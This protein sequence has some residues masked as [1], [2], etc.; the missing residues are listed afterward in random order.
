MRAWAISPAT[1][2]SANS[3]AAFSLGAV[4]SN[5]PIAVTDVREGVDVTSPRFVLDPVDETFFDT[6]PLRWRFPIDL[7]ADPDQVWAGLTARRPLWWCR[8]LTDVRFVNDPPYG[9]G[10]AR[11]VELGRTLRMEEHFFRWEEHRR[12]HSF[13]VTRANLP[14]FASFAEDYRVDATARGSRFVWT[15]AMAPRRGFTASSAIGRPMTWALLASLVRDTSRYF[16][17]G[18]VTRPSST[19]PRI[20]TDR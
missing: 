8:M 15:F 4:I 12:R 6:A 20:G 3:T 1:N 14:L 19:A 18:T 7:A 9:P 5:T 10:A 16:G 17:S 13:Y 2:S 11:T